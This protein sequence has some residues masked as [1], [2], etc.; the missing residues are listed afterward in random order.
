M[1][2]KSLPKTIKNY[3]K[4][5]LVLKSLLLDVQGLILE[6]QGPILELRMVIFRPPEANFL[7]CFMSTATFFEEKENAATSNCFSDLSETC[8]LRSLSSNLDR[9]KKGMPNGKTKKRGS[10]PWGLKIADLRVH[11]D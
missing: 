3:K 9:T 10:S 2:P 5:D 7:Y 1:E 6:V 11:A 4:S 8:S